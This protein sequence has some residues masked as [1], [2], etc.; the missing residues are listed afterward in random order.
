MPECVEVETLATAAGI[1][2]QSL[3]QVR[4]GT[5]LSLSDK[6][7]PSSSGSYFYI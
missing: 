3:V 1:L 2:F 5:L 4:T 6:K 7:Y